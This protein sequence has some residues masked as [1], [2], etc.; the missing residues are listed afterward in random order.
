[1]MRGYISR[2]LTTQ[3]YTVE[4]TADGAAALAAARRQPPSLVLT[5]VMMPHLDG[6]GLLHAL[7]EDPILR[8]VPVVRRPAGAG[9]QAHASGVAACAGDYL[10][11]PFSS[12]EVLARVASSLANARMR[13][14]TERALRTEVAERI[15][16]EAALRESETR[17]RDLAQSLET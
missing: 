11:E 16:T 13:R 6:F 3:G 14:E 10:I 5:D 4:A 2:L 9:E 7:R 12:R 15:Q 17:F 1:D 8:E